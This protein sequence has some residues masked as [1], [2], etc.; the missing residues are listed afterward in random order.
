VG[1][2][3][4]DAGDDA[5]MD[6]ALRFFYVYTSRE[7]GNIEDNEHIVD[8]RPLVLVLLVLL[9]PFDPQPIAKV[10]KLQD[11]VIITADPTQPPQPTTS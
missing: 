10:L 5:L 8:G 4:W 3:R 2:C 7:G 6:D 1:W 9:V 11:P